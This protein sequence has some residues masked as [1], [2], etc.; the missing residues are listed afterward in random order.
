[1][2]NLRGIDVKRFLPL[3][4]M[5]I[6]AFFDFCNYLYNLK[7]EYDKAI[8]AY[9]RAVALNPNDSKAYGNRGV[10]YYE[11]GQYD[12]AIK[13]FNRLTILEPNIVYLGKLFSAATIEDLNEE[14]DSNPKDFLA[15]YRRGLEY[16][17]RGNIDKAIPDFRK[18]CA[19]GYK[20]GCKELQKALKKRKPKN[21]A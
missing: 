13:D 11:K 14:I 6:D 8:E 5:T 3:V 20:N 15:Y 9:T 17:N 10:L 18:I 21:V 19:M 16:M 7:K 1:M 12:M 2:R 4:E